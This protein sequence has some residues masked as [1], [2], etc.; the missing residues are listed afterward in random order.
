MPPSNLARVFRLL[1]AGVARDVLSR[2]AL[3]EAAEGKLPDLTHWIA[4]AA[5]AVKPVLLGLFQAGM[6][7]AAAR[8]WRPSEGGREGFRSYRPAMKALGVAWDLYNPKVLDAVEQAAL[9]LCRET[10][11]TARK[12]AEKALSDLREALERG[13]SRGEAVAAV[14]RRVRRI[15]SDPH[16]AAR[17]AATEVPRAQNLGQMHSSK[18]MGATTKTWHASADACTECA[19]LDGETV[20]IDEP[21]RVEGTGPYAACYCPPLHPWCDCM[22]TEEY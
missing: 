13:L 21:F 20:G 17:I 18:E 3:D 11:E 14:A 2:V 12:D 5:Q 8:R 19:E 4:P 6:V 16:R 1:F 22:Q 10:L 9:A 15:F 7:R